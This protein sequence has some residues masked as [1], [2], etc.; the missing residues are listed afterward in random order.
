MSNP[1][2]RIGGA[3]SNVAASYSGVTQTAEGAATRASAA[4]RAAGSGNPG[5][6]R[7]R[8]ERVVASS[9]S[10]DQLDHAAPRGSYINILT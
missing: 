2:S 5:S 4:P 6:G 1:T 10:A 8:V 9:Q 7:G 3:P